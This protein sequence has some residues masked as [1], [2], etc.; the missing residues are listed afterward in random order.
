[1]EWNGLE[2]V[3]LIIAAIPSWLA[4]REGESFISWLL[5]GAGL[6]FASWKM[7]T[8]LL[9]HTGAETSSLQNVSTNN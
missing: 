8:T 7:Y 4:P 1:M 6:L 5:V 9:Y 2:W 3:E